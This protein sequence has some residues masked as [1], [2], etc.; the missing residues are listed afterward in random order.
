MS[1]DLH[2]RL[3]RAAGTPDRGPDIDAALRRGTRL[4]RRRHALTGTGLVI[5]ATAAMSIGALL[6]GLLPQHRVEL[7]PT[8]TGPPAPELA[9]FDR[10]RTPADELPTG[11]SPPE[12]GRL[13]VLSDE[14]RLAVEEQ[15]LAVYLLPAEGELLDIDGEPVDGPWLCVVVVERP[16]QQER[17]AACGVPAPEPGQG[18]WALSARGSDSD[19]VAVVVAGEGLDTARTAEGEVAIEDSV[20]LLIGAHSVPPVILE[21][22][23]GET[24]VTPANQPDVGPSS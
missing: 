10:A 2:D 7:T 12:A 19:S 1:A 4:R 21:G 3:E 22:P 16:E 17:V 6:S 23:A 5:A 13:E 14:S 24:T 9:V 8:E 15:D 18:V 20:A 11:V